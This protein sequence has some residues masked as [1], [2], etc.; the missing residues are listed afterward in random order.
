MDPA[1]ALKP[2][3]EEGEYSCT[4]LIPN[5]VSDESPARV[6]GTL[7]LEGG[8]V[9]TGHGYGPEVPTSVSA[10]GLT[11]L[12]QTTYH[13]A[14]KCELA[15]GAV[16]TLLN[17]RLRVWAPERVNISASAVLVGQGY[18]ADSSARICQ[19]KTQV[20][21]L[22]SITA[23]APLDRAIQIPRNGERVTFE[24]APSPSARLAWEDESAIL[25]ADY[26]SSAASADLYG[27]RHLFSPTLQLDID[28]PLPFLEFSALWIDPI[29][30]LAAVSIGQRQAITHVTAVGE[31]EDGNDGKWEVFAKGVTQAP[32]A[33]VEKEVRETKSALAL[34]P[35]G[36]SLLAIIRKWNDLDAMRHPIIHSFGREV[37][38][39]TDQTPRAQFLTLIQALEGTHRSEEAAKTAAEED[40]FT[41]KRPLTY[42]STAER[43]FLKKNLARK[44]PSGLDRALHWIDEGST[45]SL[46]EAVGSLDIIQAKLDE[47]SATSWA[48]AIR[49]IRNDY[50]H[51]N[52]SYD[53]Y[54]LHELVEV[55]RR[56]AT[57][58]CLRLLGASIAS[59]TRAIRPTV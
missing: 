53:P 8:R 42:L 39:L 5:G 48:D 44:P 6:P 58:T 40:K 38:S 46:G 29:H 34:G 21:G 36:D 30:R 13:P 32:Y 22:E 41:L 18:P 49:V 4:W 33:S 16:A 24:L 11:S 7:T 2:R 28:E 20:T 43:K 55:L 19:I 9:P 15:I 45:G 54:E 17:A 56:F 47:K 50:S 59:R 25:I 37:G 35:D 52:R 12:P 51:A 10:S 26:A 23:T 3:F 1:T 31:D 27:T 14:L 57:E